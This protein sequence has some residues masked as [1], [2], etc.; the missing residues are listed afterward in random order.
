MFRE[1][2]TGAGTQPL[3]HSI[4]MTEL[5]KAFQSKRLQRD[6]SLP[7]GL[8]SLAAALVM[9]RGWRSFLPTWGAS[10]DVVCTRDVGGPLL[11]SFS[12]LYSLCTDFFFIFFYVPWGHNKTLPGASEAP[13]LHP[14]NHSG[15][16][17]L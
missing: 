7:P 11:S 4:L 13:P 14:L 8:P 1:T 5:A 10:T 17:A 16:L 6:T 9:S 3:P 15:I 2:W 12:W